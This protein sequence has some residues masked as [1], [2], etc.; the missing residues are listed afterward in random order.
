MERWKHGIQGPIWS[1]QPVALLQCLFDAGRVLED[2]IGANYV[3]AFIPKREGPTF[4]NLHYGYLY[5]FEFREL[6]R[7]GD[8]LRYDLGSGDASG[9]ELFL[10][11]CPAAVS[12][13]EIEHVR[14]GERESPA[15]KGLEATPLALI[16]ILHLRPLQRL[17]VLVVVR[18]C[19]RKQAQIPPSHRYERT[20]E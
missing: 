8:H 17:P 13:A 19:G 15:E 5:A 12:A 7:F 3:K 20:L 14:S 18:Q 10:A 2:I 1:E 11:D 9:S 6:P 4:F 16:L